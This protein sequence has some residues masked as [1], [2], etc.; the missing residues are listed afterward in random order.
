MREASY[1]RE[2]SVTNMM[3][4]LSSSSAA[5]DK[6]SPSA[7]EPT[8]RLREWRIRRQLTQAELAAQM[9]VHRNSI[10]NIERGV[11][12][13][14]SP[15]TAHALATAL[16]TTVEELGVRV[17]NAGPPASVR[18]RKLTKD[19][20]EIVG[21][22]L[23]LAPDQLEFIREAIRAVRDRQIHSK[24]TTKTRGRAR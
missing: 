19:Q 9:G 24:R 5:R 4:M 8:S 16:Q 1:T 6:K 21:E 15:E 14:I 3:P 2:P 20:R 12:R 23:S 17:K 11:T 7:K 18:M 22:L 13:E 10:R